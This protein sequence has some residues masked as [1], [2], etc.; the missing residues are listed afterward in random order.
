MA[1]PREHA[2]NDAI[3]EHTELVVLM[4]L[5]EPDEPAQWSLEELARELGDGLQANDAVASLDAAGLV[6]RRD[7]L[8][9]ATRA[10]RRF[11]RLIGGL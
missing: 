6:R 9:T 11:S 1:M 8:I 2:D 5:L 3:D 10:A 4:L 7:D